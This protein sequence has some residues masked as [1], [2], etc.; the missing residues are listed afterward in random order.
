[1]KENTKN[2]V[3]STLEAPWLKAASWLFQGLG[4]ASGVVLI[5]TLLFLLIVPAQNV[6]TILDISFTTPELF[7]A[8]VE[9]FGLLIGFSTALWVMLVAAWHLGKDRFA[10]GSRQTVRLS[11][12]TVMTET[13][14]IMPI[15]FLLSFGLAQLSINMIAGILANVAG[16]SA[17]RAVWIWAPEAEAGRR[18]T[19]E[20]AVTDRARVAAAMV[21]TPVASGEYV[22]PGAVFGGG[23]SDLSNAGTNMRRGIVKGQILISNDFLIRAASTGTS[24]STSMTAALGNNQNFVIQSIRK[25]SRAFQCTSISIKREDGKIGAT[26]SYEHF[27]GMPFVGSV[28]AG[29][30]FLSLPDAPSE[31]NGFR[32]GYYITYTRSY[33]LKEQ[34]AKV[35]INPPDN[36]F[37]TS[38]PPP[39]DGA[40]GEIT[41]NTGSF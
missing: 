28:M 35:N 17:T 1:V 14:I 20:A 40:E 10:Q 3:E 8:S 39:Y 21:M 27:I 16:W 25:F 2:K 37:L 30:N 29:D 9:Q 12:G 18:G 38:D 13:L 26:F 7:E 5:A 23:S 24:T 33:M 22:N 31:K 15:F 6:I 36:N 34:Q 4:H 41:S 11:H 32:P 19:N